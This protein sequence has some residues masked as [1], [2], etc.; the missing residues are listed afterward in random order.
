MGTKATEK[1]SAEDTIKTIRRKTKR[2]HRA[3]EKICIV[4]KGLR[5]EGTV[6]EFCYREV[7][8]M[9]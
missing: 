2:K 7:L 3:E 6:P 5:G 1:V 9:V 8:D 4:L